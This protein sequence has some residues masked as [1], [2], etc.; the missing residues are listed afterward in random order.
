M[1]PTISCKS[2]S[3]RYGGIRALDGLDLELDMTEPTG[4]V[5]AN[6]AGKST[7]F[8]LL[9]GFIKPSSGAVQVMGCHPA[10]AALK[11]NISILPQDT[12]MYRNISVMAQLTHFARLQGFS[13]TAARKE[14]ER[15]LGL[16][17]ATELGRQF[18]ETLSF[19]Q[20]KKVM[21]AQALI[22][23]PRLILLDEPTSGLDPV[24]TRE[25]HKLLV[26]L[27]TEHS[28]MISSHNLGEIE[29]ICRQIVV[30]NRGKLVK[31]GTINEIKGVSRCFR[32]KLDKTP[33]LDLCA[34]LATV[35]DVARVE[36]EGKNTRLFQ[37]YY[38][39]G[40]ARSVQMAVLS[41]LHE[42]NI[43]IVEFSQGAALADEI[44]NLLRR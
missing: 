15:V 4:L 38:N 22:G 13:R 21:L 26:Q 12:A 30:I 11:G 3:K 2:V 16:I 31:T 17:L 24:A 14:V 20:R 42:Q 27:A 6:G 43:E 5:G 35:K 36:A 32:L 19:G 28:L 41:K 1:S 9:C 8:S 23:Q 34:L 7:L 37:V 18:P 10:A 33:T 25:I 29:G 40:S 39:E 44:S